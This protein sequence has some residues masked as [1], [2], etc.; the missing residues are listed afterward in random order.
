MSNETVSSSSQVWLEHQYPE[1]ST[2]SQHQ[3]S[4]VEGM[5]NQRGYLDISLGQILFFLTCVALL[6][7]V[8]IRTFEWLWPYVKAVI[9][10]ATA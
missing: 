6:G 10:G 9:H 7:Y 2:M 8:V 1:Q 5:K 3:S 4:K